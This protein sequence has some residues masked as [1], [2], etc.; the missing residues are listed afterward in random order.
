[1]WM[2]EGRHGGVLMHAVRWIESI[3]GIGSAGKM[4]AMLEMDRALAFADVV[5]LAVLADTHVT[6]EELRL[7]IDALSRTG[8]S[9]VSSEEALARW[10]TM[11]DG[12][13]STELLGARI[14]YARERLS[15]DDCQEA[16]ELVEGLARE[17]SGLLDQERVGY[18]NAYKSSPEALLEVFRTALFSVELAPPDDVP[19]LDWDL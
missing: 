9:R 8:A 1:M 12:I 14:R 10:R 3:L 4:T 7:L 2:G 18:R 6:D 17:G 13:G 5:A 11:V 16:M 19:P 15:P